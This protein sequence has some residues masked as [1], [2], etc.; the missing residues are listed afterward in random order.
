MKNQWFL[1]AI[2]VLVS[3]G[4]G[5]LI[6]GLPD[7]AGS[8]T[9]ITAPPATDAPA[10]DTTVA[11]APAPT[12]TTTAPPTT[13]PI[14]EPTADS[15][16][17]TAAEVAGTTTAP[18]P[19]VAAADLVVVAANGAGT[20]GLAA[21]FRDQLTFFG[22]EQ[23]RATDGTTVVDETVVYY[24]DGFEREAA[25]VA[26]LFEIDPDLVRPV[27]EA[28]EYGTVD[29]DQVVVYLGRDRS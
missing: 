26:E 29:G 13:E 15:T 7:T 2:V 4:A 20:Q 16:T 5:V 9:T 19:T 8:A 18:E 24:F 27:A 25:A 22:F 11:P 14:E 17:T 6:A 3:A 12:T 1:Y 28:P 23:A 10:P 21:S